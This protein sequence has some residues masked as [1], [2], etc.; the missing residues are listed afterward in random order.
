MQ[1]RMTVVVEQSNANPART[2]RHLEHTRQDRNPHLIARLLV[3]RVV[4]RSSALPPCEVHGD[5][6]AG[7]GERG[8]DA[9]GYEERL[10]AEGPDVGDE[11]DV[12][13]ALSRVPRGA[14]C[15]P[16]DEKREKRDDPDGAAD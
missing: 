10:Q 13:I 9:A 6:G 3:A 12:R 1:T 11:G 15:E 4:G 7:E 2:S 8:D 14:F 16:V 5:D